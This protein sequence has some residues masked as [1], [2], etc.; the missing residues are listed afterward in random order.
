MKRFVRSAILS[1]LALL[2]ITS[3]SY[4]AAIAKGKEANGDAVNEKGKDPKG[5]DD[6]G[7]PTE[8]NASRD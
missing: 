3:V 1:V 2:P 7:Q 8:S 5:G 6:E 4:A